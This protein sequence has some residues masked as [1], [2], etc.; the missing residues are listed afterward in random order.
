MGRN[1]MALCDLETAYAVNFMEYVNRKS[2]N[3]PFEVHA[4]TSIEQLKVFLENHRVELLLISEQAMC[5]EVSEYPIGKLIILSEGIHKPNFEEYPSVN[6][7]QPSSSLIREV[8]SYYAEEEAEHEEGTVMKENT[9]VIGVYS[10]VGRCLKTSFAITLGELLGKER[11]ALYLNFESCSGFPE[12]F[13]KT[14]KRD[15]SDLIYYLR[16][17]QSNLADKVNAMIESVG[18][19]DYLPP[20]RSMQ[21]LWNTSPEEWMQLLHL[22]KERTNYEILILD[23]G[24]AMNG[25]KEMLQFCDLIYMPVRKDILADAKLAQFSELLRL[26]KCEDL[27]EKIRKINIP[28][29]PGTERCDRYAEQLEFGPLG[30]FTRQ[31]IEREGFGRSSAERNRFL[32]ETPGRNGYRRV[33]EREGYGRVPEQNGYSRVPEK[34]GYGRVPEQDSCSRKQAGRGMPWNRHITGN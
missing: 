10:P 7:Y 22:L 11:A 19:L 3:V 17:E 30:D 8:L 14:Y 34:D 12:L 16:Q 24:S 33:P 15:L 18:N 25:L 4:F 21:D 26:W 6:K 29:K 2:R 32:R 31:Q 1:V 27:K 9:E 13:H 28:Y 5:R 23:F 20:V